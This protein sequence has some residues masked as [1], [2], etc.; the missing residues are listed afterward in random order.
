MLWLCDPVKS[1]SES[2]DRAPAEPALVTQA[3]DLLLWL[4]NH[5][6]KFPRSHRFILGERIETGAGH[7]EPLPFVR[8]GRVG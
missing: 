1:E 2:S 4:I 5:V 3:Y 8:G 7:S 6:V